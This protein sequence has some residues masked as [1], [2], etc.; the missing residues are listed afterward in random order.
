MQKGH[1][2]RF[3]RKDPVISIFGHMSVV[4]ANTNQPSRASW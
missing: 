1:F 4:A 3:V 2:H